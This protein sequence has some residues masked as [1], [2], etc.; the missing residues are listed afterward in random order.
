MYIKK[1]RIVISIIAIVLVTAVATTVIINPFG[2]KNIDDFLR[3]SIVSKIIDSVYY[4]DIDKT[5]ASNMAIAGVAASTG[6]P[7]TNYIWGDFATQYMKELQGSYCG[8]GLYI[9]YDMDN[10]LISVVSA[11][12]GSPAE[13]AGIGSGDKILK[14]DGEIYLGEQLSEAASY[15]RG[16]EG[17]DVV[18][19]IRNASD[20]NERD[21]TLTRS[22]I[23][24][25]SVECEMLDDVA[26]IRV[27]QFTEGVADDFAEIYYDLAKQGASSLVI[28][29][30]NNPGG[31]LDEAIDMASLFV[32]R[33]EIVTYT[34][35]KNGNKTEYKSSG[36]EK[37]ID[38]PTVIL[39]N[40]GS[41]SASEVVSGALK[42]YGKAVL[43]GEKS[44]GKGVVQSAMELGDR[45]VLSVTIARYYTPN[46]NCIHG[47]GLHPDKEV[48]MDAEKAARL[49]SVEPSDDEQLIAAIEYLK[50]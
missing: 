21:V 5:E 15:M 20:S 31:L 23:E 8:V 22:Q 47:E 13:K 44:Y 36:A 9:E 10:N 39:L 37:M 49:S 24:I 33:G 3:F 14:L 18:L 46:G 34:L 45:A 38:I 2:I 7:Y 50:K 26:Y 43:M 29:L 16:E 32:D 40:A 48:V 35:D 4:E 19:T 1:S 28:D 17:T 41:A 27:T 11:I 12:A 30:R 25:A 6:D 42:D